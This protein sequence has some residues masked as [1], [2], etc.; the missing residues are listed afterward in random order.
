MRYR[1]CGILGPMGDAREPPCLLWSVG[2]RNLTK[3]EA[4]TCRQSNSYTIHD[5]E[6]LGTSILFFCK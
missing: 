4:S 5:I 6:K 3:N 2:R 1:A